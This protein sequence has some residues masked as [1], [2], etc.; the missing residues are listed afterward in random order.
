MDN[1]GGILTVRTEKAEDIGAIR[2]LNKK[3][4]KGNDESKLID[5]IRG[6]DGFI[7]GLSLAAEKDGKI[8]GH[9]LFSPVKIKGP[10]GAAPALALAPMA[11]L[12]AF[13]NQ[14]I[15]TELVKRGLE[16]CRKLGHKIVVV[17]GHA[18]YYPRFGF[19]K[20]GEKGLQ[21]PFEAPEEIFMALELVP[22]A[23]DEVKGTVEYPP[24]FHAVT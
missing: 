14:G 6:S 20:A 18:G 17:V 4:F 12:P 10:A 19:V 3:A 13:Q 23:L 7:P 5:A 21:L 22:G 16:E 24:A 8:V 2:K 11:V 1:T 15:G 9:I